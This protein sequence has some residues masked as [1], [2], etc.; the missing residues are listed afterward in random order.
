MKNKTK[1]LSVL[2]ICL[3]LAGVTIFVYQSKYG[4][5][6]LSGFVI[7]QSGNETLNWPLIA[8]VGQWL[9]LL[10]ALIIAGVHYLS[11]YTTKY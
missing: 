6:S 4:S 11:P 9:L 1:F 3:V 5:I 2:A 8:L 7:N 10:L